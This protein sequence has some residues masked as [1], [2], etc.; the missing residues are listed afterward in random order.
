MTDEVEFSE[1]FVRIYSYGTNNFQFKS[2]I[3]LN[4]TNFSQDLDMDILMTKIGNATLFSDG[5]RLLRLG[6]N[7]NKT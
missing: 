1:R 6:K 3:N 7:L 4:S 2:Q 5:S